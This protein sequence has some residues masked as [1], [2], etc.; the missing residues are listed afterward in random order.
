M[1]KS[2][3]HSPD[4]S[5][6]LADGVVGGATGISSPRENMTWTQREI[7]NIIM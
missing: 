4:G 7:S 1:F 5:S 2:Q 3:L 6:V